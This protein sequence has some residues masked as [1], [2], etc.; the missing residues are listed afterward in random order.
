MPSEET[1]V[2]RE[3]E[4]RAVL[5]NVGLRRS[6]LII[7]GAGVGKSAMLRQLAPAFETMGTYLPT[8]RVGPGFTGF[9]RELFEGL[10]E[11]EAVSGAVG[12]VGAVGSASDAGAVGAAGEATGQADLISAP[13]PKSAKA[14]PTQESLWS[15]RT[16][17]DARRAAGRDYLDAAKQA[18]LKDWNRR[19]PNNDLKARW[20]VDRLQGVGGVRGT[21]GVGSAGGAGGVGTT[22]AG[23]VGGAGG[24][25]VVGGAG[26]SNAIIVIDD[27]QGVTPSNRPWLERLTEVATVVAAVDPAALY[28]AGSKRFWKRFDEVRLE[29][30]GAGDAS[31]LLERLIERYGVTADEPEIYR[32]RVLE[33]AQGNPFELERLVKHLSAEKIVRSRELGHLGQGFVE[34]D[35]KQLA[36]APLLTVGGALAIAGRYVARAQGDLDMYVLSGIGIAAFV[37]VRPLFRGAMRP[38]SRT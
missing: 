18:A 4:M 1:F 21:R 12:A 7:G 28:K 11:R 23:G 35:V 15:P 31:R 30:L 3:A 8:T 16:L 27:A 34:R 20:L 26:G 14:G 2:G 6:T 10:W 37:V 33:I 32:R 9:L 19:Y 22:G 29:A 13:G 24:A 38:R 17:A 25:G 5:D 36:L